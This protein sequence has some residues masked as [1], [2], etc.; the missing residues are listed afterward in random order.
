MEVKARL[1]KKDTVGKKNRCERTSKEERDRDR[2]KKDKRNKEGGGREK[3]RQMSVRH[4]Q[5]GSY[6]NKNLIFFCKKHQTE[7]HFKFQLGVE[8]YKHDSCFF[9]WKSI[10]RGL[11]QLILPLLTGLEGTVFYCCRL[12]LNNVECCSC[13]GIQNTCCSMN[14]RAHQ[15]PSRPRSN[16]LSL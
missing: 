11:K 8:A 2:A 6:I 10:A 15:G 1:C 5:K 12:Q 13:G 4:L 3:E 9:L 16:V 7:S 14:I